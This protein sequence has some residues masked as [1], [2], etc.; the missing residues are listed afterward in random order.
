MSKTSRSI[1]MANAL[2]LV[3]DDTAA[4]PAKHS[5][6][7]ERA[8]IKYFFLIDPSRPSVTKLYAAISM[9]H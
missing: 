3:D 2:R 1:Q 6:R 9:H 4:L 7:V 5:P 8:S